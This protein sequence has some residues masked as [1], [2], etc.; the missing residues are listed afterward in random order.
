MKLQT[1]IRIEREMTRQ[2]R[3]SPTD[4]LVE[5]ATAVG[6]ACVFWG[7]VPV[8]GRAVGGVRTQER[9]SGHGHRPPR[10]RRPS[11]APPPR[12]H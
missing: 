4:S 5:L 9:G 12:A 3:H 11:V 7:A 6:S 2:S 10:Q 1:E 8:G